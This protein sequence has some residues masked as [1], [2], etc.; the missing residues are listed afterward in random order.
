M[1]YDSRKNKPVCGK[2]R[3]PGAS[4]AFSQVVHKVM[5]SFCGII[6]Q[7]RKNHDGLDL[8]L[9]VRA[10][11]SLV[12]NHASR[13]KDRHHWLWPRYPTLANSV[14]HRCRG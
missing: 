14:I 8:S 9:F 1:I 10:C 7:H 6:P 12:K 3:M 4:G 13:W 2:R 5:H 11:V